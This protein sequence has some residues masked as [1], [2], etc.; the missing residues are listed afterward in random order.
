MGW[1]VNEYR[2]TVR[3]DSHGGERERSDQKLEYQFLRELTSLCKNYTSIVDNFSGMS[4]EL[5]EESEERDEVKT[6]VLYVRVAEPVHELLK[7]EA[8][9]EGM[10]MNMYV[11]LVLAGRL[12]R[13]QR[14]V[15]KQL[16]RELGEQR[17]LNRE[18]RARLPA[19]VF[20]RL[21]IESAYLK[22]VSYSRAMHVDGGPQRIDIGM[23]D[24]A[25]VT[26]TSV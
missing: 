4:E 9:A 13:P 2:V 26:V 8:E 15:T 20:I 17:E 16:R 14:D 6:K 25:V 11:S 5:S 19:P 3:L 1:Q 12:D 23:G 22:K 21:T 7:S 18:L 24:V 10:T